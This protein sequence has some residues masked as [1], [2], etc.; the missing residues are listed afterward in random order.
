VVAFGAVELPEYTAR[1]LVGG[2]LESASELNTY[3]YDVH[4]AELP[5]RSVCV[6]QSV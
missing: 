5:I 1:G 3:Y 4:T 2:F 6:D